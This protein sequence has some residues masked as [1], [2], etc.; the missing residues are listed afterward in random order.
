MS[1]H[2]LLILT[3]ILE[4]SLAFSAGVFGYSWVVALHILASLSFQTT[5]LLANISSL[6]WLAVYFLVLQSPE[7]VHDASRKL[8]KSS[9]NA[10]QAQEY[11]ND[12]QDHAP[13]L[14][15][16]VLPEDQEHP[17]LVR[18]GTHSSGLHLSN[19]ECCRA[20]HTDKLVD[21]SESDVHSNLDDLGRL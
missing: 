13:D 14:L 3:M 6:A 11:N 8:A 1:G 4:I 12:S 9:S 2:L 20:E 15:P 7:K 5:L 16:A 19:G 17:L 21:A 18:N 10:S